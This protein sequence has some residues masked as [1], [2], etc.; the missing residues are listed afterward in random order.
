MQVRQATHDDVPRI[1]ELLHE[2]MADSPL[3]MEYGGDEV[4]CRAVLDAAISTPGG[5]LL[6]VAEDHTGVFSFVFG[7]MDMLWYR[8]DYVMYEQL[9]YVTPERRNSTAFLRLM[10]K[11][12]SEASAMGASVI[13]FGNTLAMSPKLDKTLRKMGYGPLGHTYY[14]EV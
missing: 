9:I 3:Q 2:C 6:L 4:H 1:I 13:H 8:A 12:E 14:K 7:T 10:R 11:F 5:A